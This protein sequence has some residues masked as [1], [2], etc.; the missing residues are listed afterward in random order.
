MHSFFS[1]TPKQDDFYHLM[2]G[3]FCGEAWDWERGTNENTKRPSAG[4][5]GC[6]PCVLP[7]QTICWN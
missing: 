4:N 1:V 6:G 2:D 3:K 5:M 7:R